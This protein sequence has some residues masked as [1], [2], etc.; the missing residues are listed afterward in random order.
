MDNADSSHDAPAEG[1][2]SCRREE[3][4]SPGRSEELVC[5][6]C[7]PERYRAAKLSL[8][9]YLLCW[10]LLKWYQIH[11]INVFETRCTHCLVAFVFPSSETQVPLSSSTGPVVGLND[12]A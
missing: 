11:P 7:Q 12:N 3:Q 1:D 2:G 6:T 10:A 4:S 8:A 9:A 5:V